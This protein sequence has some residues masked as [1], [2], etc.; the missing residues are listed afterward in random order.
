MN[1]ILKI[2]RIVSGWYTLKIWRLRKL[3]LLNLF[4]IKLLSVIIINTLSRVDGVK[5][6][7]QKSLSNL[8]SGWSFIL[9]TYVFLHRWKDTVR[10]PFNFKEHLNSH[11][12]MLQL[13]NSAPLEWF[14]PK[15]R[16][17]LKTMKMFQFPGFAEKFLYLILKEKYEKFLR[18]RLKNW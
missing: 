6:S 10:W 12:I 15:I 13:P 7:R 14:I 3:L 11:P 9:Q 8:H 18:R 16:F 5:S 2:L 17:R 4:I 1:F